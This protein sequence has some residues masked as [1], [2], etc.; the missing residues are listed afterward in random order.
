MQLLRYP[1]RVNSHEKRRMRLCDAQNGYIKNCNA[2]RTLQFFVIIDEINDQCW[3]GA[4][5]MSTLFV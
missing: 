2:E 3:N 4:N 5:E 1:D